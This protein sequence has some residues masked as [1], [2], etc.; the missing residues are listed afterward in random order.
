MEVSMGEVIADPA[1]IRII[2]KQLLDLSVQLDK[3]TPTVKKALILPG[4]VLYAGDLK[5]RYGQRVNDEGAAALQA[6]VTV[7]RD[8][9]NEL[10]DIAGDYETAEDLNADDLARLQNV[11]SGVQKIFPSFNPFPKPVV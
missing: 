6:L 10:I 8:M 11:I 3:L 2:G 4:S 9:G 1:R 7:L 5:E